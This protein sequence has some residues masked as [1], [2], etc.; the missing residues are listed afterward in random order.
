MD[1]SLQEEYT[2]GVGGYV[3]KELSEIPVYE[4]VADGLWSEQKS[5]GSRFDE[6]SVESEKNKITPLEFIVAAIGAVAA[7]G[8][9]ASAAY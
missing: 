8:A 3:M 2:M 9:I 7:A 1:N 5:D 6:L 4:P